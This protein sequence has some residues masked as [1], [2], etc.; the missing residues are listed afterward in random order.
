MST[1]PV[2]LDTFS[3]HQAAFSTPPQP[4]YKAPL[5]VPS[6]TKSFWSTDPTASPS[7]SEGSGG[8]L[9]EDADIC[10]IGSGITG[11]SAAYHLA[12][13]FKHHNITHSDD[14]PITV[15]MLEAR[16]FC[17]GATGRNG[18]HLTAHA[19]LNFAGLE[20]DRGREEAIRCLAIE[21]YTVQQITQLLKDHDKTDYVDFVPGGRLSL[22]FSEE[23]HARAMVDYEAAKKA[24]V[25]LDG[26]HWLTKEE[27]ESKYGAP[28]PAYF[29]PGNNLWPLK[30]NG[31][32]FNLAN[33]VDPSRFTANLHTH[34]PVTSIAAL[35]TED[36][37]Q[38]SHTTV[39]FP[40]RW[41]L[42][43][44]RGSITSSIIIH[45]TNGYA[46]HLLPHLG[47]PSGIVPVRGQVMATRANVSA[48][49]LTRVGARAN[50]GLEYWFPR[51]PKSEEDELRPLVIIGG[52][53]EVIQPGF[54]L[55][56][57]DDSVVDVEIGK[58]MREF[59]PAVFPGRF[60][61]GKQPEIEWTGIMGFTKSKDPFVGPVFDPSNPS[62]VKAFKGQY[63]S[64]GYT[65][66]GMPRAYACTEALSQIIVSDIL[67]TPW[68]PP[69]WL[70]R[71][72]ITTSRHV[73]RD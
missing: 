42:T 21:K 40:R 10:I 29:T 38:S 8:I 60:E 41:Q 13:T 65:G 58:V 28:Y 39:P 22:L 45:A 20:R 43:T 55:Y 70:P 25:P 6:P 35:P 7:P 34:T 48:S 68:T 66:H 37:S 72:Y 56:E 18:G 69:D 19:F 53:R 17:S 2:P 64:A 16:D 12:K 52:G 63:I 54:E 71:G 23:E 11:C 61:R 59:L 14:R 30:L 51:P 26:V 15:V 44:P 33:E 3:K 62:S 24:G 50:G 4:N 36:P 27:V 46:S 49:T 9:S 57:T 5:P 47:G 67:G 32:L 31:V 1:L 73:T